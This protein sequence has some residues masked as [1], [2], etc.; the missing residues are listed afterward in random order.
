MEE[1][2]VTFTHLG[3]QVTVSIH[4]ERYSFG[5]G[6]AVQ[7]IRRDEEYATVSVNAGSRLADDEFVFKTYSENEGILEGLLAAGVVEKAGQFVQCG[8]AGPQPVCRLT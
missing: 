7:L 6:L 4:T 5:G 2:T 8:F 3:N 1:K